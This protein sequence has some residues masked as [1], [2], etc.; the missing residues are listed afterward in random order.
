MS[1]RLL[2]VED[3]FVAKGPGVLVMPRFSADVV[4]KGPFSVRLRFPGGAEREVTAEMD[5]A[6]MR[7]PLPPYAMYRL[8]GVTPEE[9][10]AGTEIWSVD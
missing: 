6:H 7:G 8:H 10:P 2:V 1:A 9:I 4:K 5:V 3:A